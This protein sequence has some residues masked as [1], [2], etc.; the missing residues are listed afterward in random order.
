MTLALFSPGLG[1]LLPLAG[2][3]PVASQVIV[4]TLTGVPPGYTVQVRI[5]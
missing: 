5:V 3:S 4:V 1:E 2:L